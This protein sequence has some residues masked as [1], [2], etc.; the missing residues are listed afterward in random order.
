MKHNRK[1]ILLTLATLILVVFMLAEVFTYVSLNISGNRIGTQLS[2]SEAVSAAGLKIN[3]ELRA[4]LHEEMLNAVGVASSTN[5]AAKENITNGTSTANEVQNLLVSGGINPQGTPSYLNKVGVTIGNYISDIINQAR[6]ANEN[7]SITNSTFTV[8]GVSPLLLKGT[9]TA[10][11][12]IS[13]DGI[14]STYPIN[15]NVTVP[16][17]T[18]ASQTFV[19][20]LPPGIVRFV[21][22]TLTNGQSVATAAP[23]QQMVNVNSSLYKAYEAGNLDNIEF[24]YNNYTIIPSWLESGNSNTAVNTT[25]WLN[26][27]QGIPA[28]SSIT[29]YMGFANLTT[30][31]FNNLT[32]GEAPQLSP[33][34]AQYD[35]GANVF[36]FY[37]NFAGA[38]LS[39]KWGN[40]G[41]YTYSVNNGLSVTGGVCNDVGI[42]ST[43]SFS[44]PYVIDLY[45]NYA[46]NDDMGLW[47]NIQTPGSTSDTNL[48]AIRG[49]STGAG[50]KADQLFT[51]NPAPTAFTGYDTG[52]ETG[53]GVYN[54]YTLISALNNNPIITQVNYSNHID[55]TDFPNSYTSGYIGPR[56][57]SGSYED[58]QWVRVRAYPPNGVMP[59]VS[60]GSVG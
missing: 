51:G 46:T 57:C 34:Y 8:S 32:T 12:T 47:W 39:S 4:F 13:V 31:L 22:I 55:A 24:F 54:I 10:F 33:S 60:V 42:H 11:A 56:F 25:Y 19:G 36:S 38:S 45:G 16:S 30:N 43:I 40:T 50:T 49:T 17:S 28:H 9:Y 59:R 20:N 15:V 35:D 5:I 44:D 48:W 52:S 23:F 7:L 1:G 6:S 18:T 3:L 37:D 14:N 58:W 29:V 27:S 41:T 21:P 2:E 53:N 26:I